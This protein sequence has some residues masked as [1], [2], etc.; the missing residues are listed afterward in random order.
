MATVR[1]SKKTLA[2]Y[3]A[4]RIAYLDNQ[5]GFDR[6]NGSSQVERRS[7]E[8]NRAYAEWETLRSIMEEFE[9]EA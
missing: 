2:G 3:L 1:F 9:L 5:W 7:P 8:T 6:G 4:K